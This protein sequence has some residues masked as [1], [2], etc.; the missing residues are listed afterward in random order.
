MS[1]TTASR[2]VS[3]MLMKEG[4]VCSSTEKPGPKRELDFQ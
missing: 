3:S 1:D 2:V 4:G